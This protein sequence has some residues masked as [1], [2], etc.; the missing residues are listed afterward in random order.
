MKR[1]GDGKVYTD[2][3]I[4]RAEDYVKYIKE[5]EAFAEAHLSAY[6]EPLKAAIAE[7]KATDFYS[8]RLERF[9]MISIASEGLYESI[10]GLRAP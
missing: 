4:Y 5:Q 9:M 10:E 1:T 2:F 6:T 8:L 3:I 7:L